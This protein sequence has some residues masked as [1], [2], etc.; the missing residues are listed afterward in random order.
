[1]LAN[2]SI[3]TI[4]AAQATAHFLGEPDRPFEHNMFE[5]NSLRLYAMSVPSDM[6]LAVITPTST[7]LGTVRHNMRR[8][9]RELALLAPTN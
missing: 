1:M 6:L 4:R 8:S 2:L 3:A 7:P 9:A 5:T